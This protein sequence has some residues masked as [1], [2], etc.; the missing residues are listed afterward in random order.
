[1]FLYNNVFKLCFALSGQEDGTVDFDG[2]I[3]ITPFNMKEELEEGYFDKEGTY[4]F[5]KEEGVIKDQWLEDID[6]IKVIFYF[7]PHH[8]KESYQ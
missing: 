5:Q 4:I 7:L 3:K 2:E 8:C 6:W 1:M